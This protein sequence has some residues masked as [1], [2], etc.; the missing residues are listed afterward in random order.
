MLE[1]LVS[2]IFGV[3]KL[4]ITIADDLNRNQGLMEQMEQFANGTD[5]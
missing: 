1:S 4:L 3:K 2:E 5:L